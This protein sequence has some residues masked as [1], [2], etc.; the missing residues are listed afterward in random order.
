MPK[1][2][3]ANNICKTLMADCYRVVVL[4]ICFVGSHYVGRKLDSVSLTMHSVRQ[5][6]IGGLLRFKTLR[7]RRTLQRVCRR[8]NSSSID[9]VLLWFDCELLHTISWLCARDGLCTLMGSV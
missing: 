4:V 8:G 7:A 9:S 6:V 3:C 2:A 1:S 5:A